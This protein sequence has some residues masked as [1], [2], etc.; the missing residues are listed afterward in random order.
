MTYS[1]ITLFNRYIMGHAP[2]YQR[3][4]LYKVDW[5][6]PSKRLGTPASFS[7]QI[8]IPFGRTLYYKAPKEWLLARANYWTLQL[9]D[10]IVNG[11]VDA[12]IAQVTDL[13]GNY[14]LTDLKKSFEMV[15][16]VSISLDNVPVGQQNFTIG[17][18]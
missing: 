10:V 5:G 8:K 13:Y 6:T 3:T 17:A 7:T 15:S 16:I 18:S 1:N 11:I 14:S 4:Y 9:E 2:A 12:Q